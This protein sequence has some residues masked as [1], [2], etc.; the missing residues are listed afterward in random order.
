MML[1]ELL[2]VG[3]GGA[4]GSILRFAFSLL[5]R[6]N[7][8]P[9]ATLIINIAGS[10]LLGIVIAFSEKNAIIYPWKYLLA[11]GLC[12]GFTTFST[13]SMESLEML[14]Q[15]EYLILII[16][17]LTSILLGI[18]AAWAGHSLMR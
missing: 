13:F 3:L 4:T 16:Y 5:I 2:L 18:A 1:R 17:V 14:K 12:G 9:L 15:Q 7:G 10:F 8:F 11:I 6:T